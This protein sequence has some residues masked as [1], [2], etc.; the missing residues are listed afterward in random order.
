MS[1]SLRP[2]WRGAPTLSPGPSQ[3]RQPGSP[4]E[5]P[6][7]GPGRWGDQGAESSVGFSL[8]GMGLGS[9]GCIR[10]VAHD[11]GKPL[12]TSQ[13]DVELSDTEMQ[14]AQQFGTEVCD[15]QWC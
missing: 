12:L 3:A 9:G 4:G 10:N 1:K 5:D 14:T 8:A 11:E 2:L 6:C 7:A 15:V 13:G